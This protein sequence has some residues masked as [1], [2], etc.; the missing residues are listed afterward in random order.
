MFVGFS[1]AHTPMCRNE[2]Y[3]TK[4]CSRHKEKDSTEYYLVF[5][6]HIKWSETFKTW[7]SDT[8]KNMIIYF[9]FQNLG[10]VFS[11]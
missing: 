1:L 3:Q 9:F 7:S 5:P 8:S 2:L 10:N 11:D 6:F 4:E